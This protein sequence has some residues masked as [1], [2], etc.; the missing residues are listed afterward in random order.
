[1]KAIPRFT[2]RDAMAFVPLLCFGVLMLFVGIAYQQ[3]GHWPVYSRP[4]PKDVGF[5]IVPGLR[6]G[7]VLR[8]LVPL[9][10]GALSVIAVIGVGLSTLNDLA[11]CNR[12][13]GRQIAIR[14]FSQV[15]VSIFGLL[16]FWHVLGT[17][18]EWLVD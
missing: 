7:E 4:D 17:L 15:A 3:V 2:P 9:V 18:L 14:G 1:M 11:E 10:G 12:S 13:S 6:L 16:L 8:V 5:E